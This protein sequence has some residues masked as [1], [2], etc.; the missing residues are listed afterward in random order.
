[1]SDHPVILNIPNQAPHT[2]ESMAVEDDHDYPQRCHKCT[3][4]NGA[5]GA[6]LAMQALQLVFIGSGAMILYVV[7]WKFV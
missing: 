5:I 1:M 4:Q 3:L 2:V 7:A 6:S